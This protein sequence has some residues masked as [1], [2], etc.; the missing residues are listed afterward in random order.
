MTEKAKEWTYT[1]PDDGAAFPTDLVDIV[2]NFV[3]WDT[4]ES[5]VASSIE[6]LQSLIFPA[7]EASL[8]TEE[9][10]PV[11]FRL[12]FDFIPHEDTLRFSQP[13]EYTAGNLTRLV[14]RFVSP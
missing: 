1:L 6:Q 5:Q 2:W 9:G 10:R 8:Q 7:F 3:T 4:R 12:L 13:L 11:R 14:E